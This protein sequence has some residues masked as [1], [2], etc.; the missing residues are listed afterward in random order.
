MIKNITYTHSTETFVTHPNPDEAGKFLCIE[1]SA[2]LVSF[3]IIG[4]NSVISFGDG[5]AFLRPV[6]D[7]LH[8]RVE[9]TCLVTFIGI[10]SLLTVS[11]ALQ[12]PVKA[13]ASGCD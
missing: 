4:R 2:C 3:E 8:V 13:R 5:Y 10:Q 9:A 6:A 12:S 1:F 7:G 11:F